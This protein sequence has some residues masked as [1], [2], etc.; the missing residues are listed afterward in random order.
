MPTE[1][2]PGVDGYPIKF[3]TKHWDVVNQDV[4]AVVQKF[5]SAV[6][7]KSLELYYHHFSSKNPNPHPGERLQTNSMLLQNVQNCFQSFDSEN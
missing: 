5:F 7:A 4:Y 2:A 1:K 6:N 3:F